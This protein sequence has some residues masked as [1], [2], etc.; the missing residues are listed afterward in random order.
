MTEEELQK[1]L[2]TANNIL[3]QGD[4]DKAISLYEEIITKDPNNAEA[5][6]KLA[7]LYTE[8]GMKDH[9][10]HELLLLGNAYYESR[11]FKNALKYFQ[12]ILEIDPEHIDARIKAAEIYVNE[13]M[14]REAKLE[15]LA[16][17]EYYLSSNDLDKAEEFAKKAIELK[18]I[19]A[20]YIMGLVNYKR[21]MFKEASSSFETLTK[22]KLH[23]AGALLHLGL[24]HVNNGK[25]SEATAAFERVLK[26]EPSNIEALKGLA[27]ACARKGSSMDAAG[28]YVKAMD[29]MLKAKDYENAVKF[30]LEFVKG[31]PVNPE[32]CLKLA[33]VFESKNSSEDAA[34]YYKLAGDNFSKQKNEVRSK[35]C[36]SKA[37]L[38]GQS[39]SPAAV[40][41]KSEDLIERT[42]A[43]SP[44]RSKVT[45][46]VKNSFTEAASAETGKPQQQKRTETPKEVFSPKPVV[47]KEAA[48]FA[49][50]KGEVA[51]LFEQAE[52][53]M[54]DGY[55]EKSIEI[56]RVILKK[57][58]RNNTVRQKLHQAY[59]ML[60]QQEEEIGNKAMV[61]VP[62]K[63]GPKEKK[64]KI[65]YL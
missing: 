45:E 16:I 26:T 32:G 1:L 11:L 7:D 50:E 54:N 14:E 37:N 12:R 6:M 43:P 15:Y 59:I 65:S 53:H 44:S 17:A 27:D 21:G 10:S 25:Y 29:A 58:P 2:E 39:A 31:S 33:Q 47:S 13:E 64:S 48:S 22:I 57:E 60:A 42:V 34:K 49:A 30:G 52:K 20:H 4:K 23:H 8:K 41:T 24:S 3:L 28:W 62:K 18:S 38:L 9:A 56:F 55:F 40:S 36:Y 35:E 61:D 63:D 46:S 19:E 51:E 5:H